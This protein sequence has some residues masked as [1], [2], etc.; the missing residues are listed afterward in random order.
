MTDRS[1]GLERLLLGI[2]RTALFLVPAVG[3]ILGG[4][5]ILGWT[6]FPTAFYPNVTWKNFAFRSLVEVATVF[7][8]VLAWLDPRYR[9][10]FSWITASYAIFVAILAVA[11]A[12][13]M[14]PAYSF[15]G[16]Y[17]RMEGLICHLHLL[18]FLVVLT[19]VFDS[20]KLWRALFAVSLTV[21]VLVCLNGL[22]QLYLAYL[23]ANGQ[24][25]GK[26]FLQDMKLAAMGRSYFRIDARLANPVYVAIFVVLHAFL[27]TWLALR[28]KQR[29]WKCALAGVALLCVV[30]LVG[31]GTKIAWVGLACGAMF[32]LVVTARSAAEAGIRRGTLVAT[33]VLTA[34]VVAFVAVIWYR[35][36]SLTYLGLERRFIDV[37]E[38]LNARF[39]L[40]EMVWQAF[41]ENPVL[42]WGQE[43]FGYV[44]NKY[45]HPSLFNREI[46]AWWDHP[47]N[48]FFGWLVAAGLPGL[49]AYLAIFAAAVRCLWSRAAGFAPI[50][51]G[52]FTGMLLGYC[53]FNSSQLDN[54]TSYI[55]FFSVLGYLHFRALG[56]RQ[57]E[58]APRP[59][60]LA[61]GAT[62]L[63]G[64][65]GWGLVYTVNVVN[66][67]PAMALAD[68]HFAMRSGDFP[69]MM[70]GFRAAVEAG[71]MGRSQVRD[72]I[73]AAASTVLPDPRIDAAIRRELADFAVAEFARE[74]DENP[75]NVHDLYFAGRLLATVIG[76]SREG[77]PLLERALA[78]SPQRQLFMFEIGNVHLAAG[79]TDE[80]MAMF[81]RGLDAWPASRDAQIQCL[82]AAIL[83]GDR[84]TEDELLA[85]RRR[86][87]PGQVFHID[88][89][90]V[91]A[92]LRVGRPHDA[93]EILLPIVD[94][95]IAQWESTRRPLPERAR[96]RIV[97]LGTAYDRAGQPDKMLALAEKAAEIEF[98]VNK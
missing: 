10:R 87:H 69:R 97:V 36:S 23:K 47:H 56:S 67:R 80:A 2:V 84:A 25:D 59:V 42:G 43:N 57:V 55:V 28:A 71:P 85:M 46:P 96:R 39:R 54:L 31:T 9:P 27:A 37:G 17:E 51:R 3:L 18:A 38:S 15:W 72:Q 53:I 82:I 78:L 75:G 74:V 8:L 7:W 86:A 6:P 77:L 76:N 91:D 22:Y 4:E 11:D 52:L 64:L 58:R 30:V 88:Q 24:F 63:A 93:I 68:G 65:A 66:A 33:A 21:C 95:W 61:W 40:W 81:R 1:A 45:Y 29:A 49:L 90:V 5:K 48:V 73:A 92:M 34:L 83:A 44:F 60:A 98:V 19:S 50:E 13:G 79:R 62:A 89:G 26:P 16:T 32:A 94:G 12:A 35:P 20:D 14:R 41:L 70:R